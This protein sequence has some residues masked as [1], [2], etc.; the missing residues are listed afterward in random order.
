MDVKI[1]EISLKNIK[2]I[3]NGRISFVDHD[4]ILKVTGIYGANGS[5][6]TSVITVLEFV[7]DLIFGNSISDDQ[8]LD[9]FT[10]NRT[11]EITICYY[12]RDK[13]NYF[14]EYHIVLN[15]I[16]DDYADAKLNVL[17]ERIRYKEN[18]PNHRYKTLI[19]LN[20]EEQKIS[21]QKINIE[22]LSSLFRY[23]LTEAF[24][25]Q[26][27]LLFSS[28]FLEF[29]EEHQ[30][31]KEFQH[32]KAMFDFLKYVQHNTFVSENNLQAMSQANIAIP[33][34]FSTGEVQGTT[35]IPLSNS[36]R[37]NQNQYELSQRIIQQINQ[38]LPTI[39]SNLELE[40]KVIE[41]DFD[42]DGNKVYITILIA[43]RGEKSFPFRAESEGIKKIVSILS[44]LI[45]SYNFSN[46]IVA[47]DEFDS[48]IFEF[49]LGQLLEIFNHRMKGQLIFTA[50]NL[51]P[52]ENLDVKNIVFTTTNDED[53]YIR[54]KN[55]KS[56]NNLRKVYLNQIQTNSKSYD[57]Y[58]PTQETKIKA[59]LRRANRVFEEE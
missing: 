1:S 31:I 34:L 13:K 43:H 3:I 58:E 56:S 32:L 45:F 12:I 36:Y 23:I 57:L 10:S 27:S 54:L 17:E 33:M 2:N 16:G 7:R 55:I 20:A 28:L 38:V 47:I 15:K 21:P 48:G 26:T 24:K 25:Q 35:A 18:K 40:L 49:L 50:H 42:N 6:K 53:K 8:Y 51:R 41:S 59:A 19:Y 22:D 4:D 30:N 46:V 39:I 9:L 37:M 11:S 44:A 52:L 5:G 29:V 14:V